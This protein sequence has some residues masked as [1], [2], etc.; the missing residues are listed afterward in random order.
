MD[1][2]PPRS[3]V[4]G[5]FQTRTLVAISFPRGP[6]WPRDQT[7]VSCIAGRFFTTDPPGKPWILGWP[8]SAAPQTTL[9]GHASHY[10]LFPNLKYF[11]MFLLFWDAFPLD[12]LD[13]DFVLSYLEMVCLGMPE[14]CSP[15]VSGALSSS[16]RAS[17]TPAPLGSVLRPDSTAI[18]QSANPPEIRNPPSSTKAVSCYNPMS[19]LTT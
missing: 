2:S 10:V 18:L 12:F 16:T 17:P 15:A 11:L 1:C 13:W 14:I 8:G 9:K 7:H 19:L 3:S 6:S 4:H 5:I